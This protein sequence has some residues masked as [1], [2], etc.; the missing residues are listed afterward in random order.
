MEKP[1]VRKQLF[2]VF[3]L[4]LFIL[5]GRLFYPFLTVLLWSGLL[6]SFLDPLYIKIVGQP[7][8]GKKRPLKHSIVAGIM[9]LLG[10]A[11][12]VVPV[13]FLGIALVRQVVDIAGSAVRFIEENPG[14]LDL[15]P[16]SPIGGFVNRVSGG[17]IDLSSFMIVDE[18]KQFLVDSSSKIIGYSG[19]LVKN[20]AS[21]VVS[22]AFMVFTLYFFLVDG[23]HLVSVL[24]SAVPI[25][26][27]YTSLFLRKMRDTSMQLVKGYFLVA[28]YQAVAMF[29][30]CLIF[31]VENSLVAAVLTAISSFIPML[32][33]ALVWIPL[34]I[35]L[36]LTGP[37][38]KALLFCA[39][40]AILV[41]SVDN[42]LRPLVLGDRLR[43][44]PL[45]I[46]FAIL[47]GLQIFGFNG[48]ILGP[49]ILIL[50]F[51]AVELYDQ[52]DHER[53]EENDSG[54]KDADATPPPDGGTDSDGRSV[55]A[56]VKTFILT[57]AKGVPRYKR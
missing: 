50:F 10:V 54:G 4:A 33:T 16:A 34:T 44:H 21:L 35:I 32:G 40:A 7:A 18:L 1:P 5:V 8:L 47:G 39:T 55:P 14:L 31:G 52:L 20:L 19:T 41:S 26:R 22:L 29:V 36:A 49:L 57:K 25:E 53:K 13:I 3:F 15:S 9:A 11:L 12:L 42:F 43:V 24:I 23:R 28:L 51:A 48:I 45:L 17:S 30:V 27:H 56:R 38:W 46:F 37:L 6:Y 2:L